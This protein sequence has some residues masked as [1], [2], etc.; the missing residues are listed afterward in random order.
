MNTETV[1]FKIDG[2]VCE[3]EKGKTLLQAA[4]GL[5]IWIPTLCNH[6]ALEPQGACRLC[7]VEVEEVLLRGFK[8][9]PARFRPM[10][11]MVAHTGYLIFARSLVASQEQAIAGSA[12]EEEE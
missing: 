6:E 3:I 10:D 12:S 2:T 4:R 7:M 8:T 1:T 5:S 9:V 11:R